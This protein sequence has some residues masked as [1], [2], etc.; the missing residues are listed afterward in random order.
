[1]AKQHKILVAED[2]QFLSR[3]LQD[4][5]EREGFEVVAVSKGNEVIEKARAEKP[6]LIL[7]DIMMPQKNG[8]DVLAEMKLDEEL[9][10]IPVI[11]LS[12]LGQE[13]DQKKG[14]ELGAIDYLVKA[15]TPLAVVLEKVREQL[16]KQA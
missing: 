13:S 3:A 2:D 1:M 14:M 12:N 11:F 6:A 15:D 4:K 8:F 7:M 10:D 16:A 9:K 5:S